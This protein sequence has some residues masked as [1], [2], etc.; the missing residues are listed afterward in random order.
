[1]ARSDLFANRGRGDFYEQQ[2]SRA[3]LLPTDW[4]DVL[5]RA[6]EMQHA[7]LSLMSPA[8][9]FPSDVLVTT[10]PLAVINRIHELGTYRE[11]WNR[12]DTVAPSRAALNDAEQFVQKQDF[13]SLHLPSIGAADDGEINFWWDVNGLYIDLGFF[14]DG[15]YSFYARLPDGKEILDDHVPVSKPLPSGILKFLKQSH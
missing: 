1:M 9:T 15:S 6:Y 14:G 11:G 3:V 8:S 5:L 4:N 12:P 7:M 10:A 2:P 13:A